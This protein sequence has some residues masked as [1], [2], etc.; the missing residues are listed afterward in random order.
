M[1][2]YKKAEIIRTKFRKLSISFKFTIVK[3]NIENYKYE[4]LEARIYMYL[5]ILILIN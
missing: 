4:K 1:K 3:K 2:K 5:L